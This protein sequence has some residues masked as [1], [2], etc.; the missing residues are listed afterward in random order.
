MVEF[1]TKQQADLQAALHARCAG[2]AQAGVKHCPAHI[3]PVLSD[4]TKGLL[5]QQFNCGQQYILTGKLLRCQQP[6]ARAEALALSLTIVSVDTMQLAPLPPFQRHMDLSSLLSTQ[7][8][9]SE[10]VTPQA[11]APS[12]GTDDDI[13]NAFAELD[14]DDPTFTDVNDFPTSLQL[15]VWTLN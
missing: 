2:N 14:L 15:S 11:S 1:Y 10:P 7:A 13:D 3:I 9:A 5:D 6:L 12:Y 4:A 8:D